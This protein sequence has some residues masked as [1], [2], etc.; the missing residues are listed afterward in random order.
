MSDR[1]VDA[2]SDAPE[3]ARRGATGI[4]D[5]TKS[6]LRIVLVVAL[7]PEEASN[8]IGPLDDDDAACLWPSAV[9]DLLARQMLT[10]RARW[11]W[12]AASIDRR[13]SPW[14]EQ[15]QDRSP[16]ELTQALRD[17]RQVWDAQDFA[18]LLWALVRRK[19]RALDSLF[20]R[21]AGEIE[22]AVLRIAAR[23]HGE[24]R[25]WRRAAETRTNDRCHR[26]RLA[27]VA[28]S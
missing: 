22:I 20:H 21:I 5:G 1:L 8:L 25:A 17:G 14:L 11:V 9:Y 3:E 4:F 2:G 24:A 18:A 15:F 28:S 16:I 7:S 12:G 6:A 10:S 23:P 19:N 26:T 13:L 27:A